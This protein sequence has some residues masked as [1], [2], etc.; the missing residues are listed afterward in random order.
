[1]VA[2]SKQPCHLA[3]A[4]KRCRA[5]KEVKDVGPALRLPLKECNPQQL[6]QLRAHCLTAH[7]CCAKHLKRVSK[8]KKEP[9]KRGPRES[10]T[11]AQFIELCRTLREDGAPGRRGSPP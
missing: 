5:G 2:H 1:M 11:E 3:C 4:V 8:K 7:F 6:R 9:E 10:F